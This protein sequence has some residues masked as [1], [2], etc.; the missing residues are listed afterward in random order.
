MGACRVRHAE[1]CID[2]CVDK[3]A[4]MEAEAEEMHSEVQVGYARLCGLLRATRGATAKFRSVQRDTNNV[5]E[6]L[7][8]HGFAEPG[9]LD[10]N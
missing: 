2:G 6:L 8:L 4:N 5:I 7:Y 9:S 3:K 10:D 1:L